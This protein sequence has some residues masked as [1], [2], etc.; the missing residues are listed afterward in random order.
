MTLCDRERLSALGWACARGHLSCA[1]TLLEHGADL[2]QL[3]RSGRSAL[4]LATQYGD[5]TLVSHM[6]TSYI[7][8][9]CRW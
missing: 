3:D 6:M 5:P 4:D 8:L 7:F 1:Q 2:H 9:P